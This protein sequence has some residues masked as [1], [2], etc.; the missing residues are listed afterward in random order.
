[1]RSA[2]TQSSLEPWEFNRGQD[3]GQR[4][5]KVVFVHLI[6]FALRPQDAKFNLHDFEKFCLHSEF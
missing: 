2:R 1:M 5:T 3:C 6:K 4:I